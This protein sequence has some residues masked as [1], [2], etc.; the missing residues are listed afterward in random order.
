MAPRLVT[1]YDT[2][3]GEKRTVPANWFDIPEASINL[4]LTDPGIPPVIPEGHNSPTRPDDRD[5][6]TP[7]EVAAAEAAAGE[8]KGA[9]LK[10]ALKDAGLPYS[11]LSADEQRAALV[12]HQEQQEADARAIAEADAAH[13][14][15]SGTHDSTPGDHTN[16]PP[17]G[18]QQ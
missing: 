10:A 13:A 5:F 16:P 9:D 12:A 15:N 6:P 11:G 8:L 2:R 4:S 7:G 17:A 14:A 3:T 1:A 18:D